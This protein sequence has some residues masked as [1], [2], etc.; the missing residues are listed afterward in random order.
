MIRSDDNKH[1]TNNFIIRTDRHEHRTGSE[2]Y[3]RYRIDVSYTLDLVDT[4]G[5]DELRFVSF[6]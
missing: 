2:S 6:Q 3:R 5:H 4:Y 1:Q